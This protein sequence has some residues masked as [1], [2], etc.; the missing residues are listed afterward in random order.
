[1]SMK[2]NFLKYVIPSM[3]A[4]LVTGIYTS[5]VGL[6]VGRSVGDAGIAS[7][8][9]AWPLAAIIL[10]IGTGIG[11]GGAVNMSNHMGA[12]EKREAGKAL[13]NTFTLML[14]ASAVLTVF[15]LICAKPILRF[16]G[17]EG[18][19]LEF[20]Y[21]YVRVL[22]MGSVLQVL[23]AGVT[24]LLRNQNKAWIAMVLMMT[25]FVLDT[26]LSGVFVLVL[27]YGV[28]GAALATLIGQFIALVPSLFILFKKENRVPISNYYLKRKTVQNI[29]KIAAS[30]FALSLLPALTIA[31]INWRA[32]AY[33][34]T[35]ALAAYAVVSYMLSVGQLLLQGV[36]DGSQPL[37][38][39]YHG[40]N[41]AHSVKQLK[42]WTY[43][44]S[45]TTGIVITIGIIALRNVIP[46][47]F[48][49]SA[50]T[51]GVLLFAFPLC[52]LSLPFYAFS[53]STSA[54]FYAIKKARRASIMVYCEALIVLPICIFI[55]PMFLKLNGV[56]TALTVVQVILSLGA[57]VFLKWHKSWTHFLSHPTENV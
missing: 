28:T 54:Y 3:I 7:I 4:S 5:I 38:S 34:G 56:W 30:P 20:A 22:G 12:E 6:F 2:K 8:S 21:G 16:L 27:G 48:N 18:Q 14:I 9:I 39:F 1:M 23:G 44:T 37:I 52:A 51:A 45:I 36:C 31:M 33:G 10:A 19:V 57:I 32:L 11:M 40:A 49:V 35:V 50:E 55:L 24:P 29:L 43:Y 53:R 47:W 13:G 15:I 42:R 41:N 46:T 25:N 17:A 26:V